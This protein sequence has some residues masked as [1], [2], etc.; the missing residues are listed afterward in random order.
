[1][2]SVEVH[3][4]RYSQRYRRNYDG[5]VLAGR[6]PS[7]RYAYVSSSHDTASP[8]VGVRRTSWSI[9]LKDVCEDTAVFQVTMPIPLQRIAR[10][11]PNASAVEQLIDSTSQ[12]LTFFSVKH[13]TKWI[14]E[15]RRKAISRW[16][17]FFQP[18]TEHAIC[19]S[20]CSLPTVREKSGRRE[21]KQR[22]EG[23]SFFWMSFATSSSSG[24]STISGRCWTVKYLHNVNIGTTTKFLLVVFNVHMPDVRV[25]P[26]ETR[27][28][29]P[30]SRG[31]TIVGWTYRVST[32]DSYFHIVWNT[33]QY[34][35]LP[36][37]IWLIAYIWS[38]CFRLLACIRT[39]YRRESREDIA[40]GRWSSTLALW[41]FAF[42]DSRWRLWTDQSRWNCSFSFFV[43]LLR[44]SQ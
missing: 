28:D 21:G 15:T 9:D 18:S 34:V 31:E 12:C 35:R 20:T 42:G 26:R 1:M 41:S 36:Q 10:L 37:W 4:H 23:T 8:F 29:T 33:D 39:W 19:C 2:L 38:K 5:Y 11:R 24:Q 7:W 22:I 16:L 44:R 30:Q 6:C 43:R 40:D 25:L 14:R 3:E 27:S 13:T 32:S 17:A